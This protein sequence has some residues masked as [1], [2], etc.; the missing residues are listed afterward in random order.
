MGR[1]A[2]DVEVDRDDGRSAVVD[3]GVVGEGAAV[4]GARAAGDDDAGVGQGGVSLFKG[5]AHVLGDRAGD[6]KGVGVPGGRDE[7]DAETAHV[8]GRGSKHVTV[9]FTGSAATGG[10]LAQL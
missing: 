2:G 6:Q 4:D 1:A 10:Y 7:L 5:Q 9:G 8:P 3:F